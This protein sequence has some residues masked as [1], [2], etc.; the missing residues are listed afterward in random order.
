MVIR[1]RKCAQCKRRLEGEHRTQPSPPH[2]SPALLREREWLVGIRTRGG[3]LGM[4]A[5]GDERPSLSILFTTA[6]HLLC[7]SGHGGRGG[8]FA[9]GVGGWRGWREEPLQRRALAHDHQAC[10]V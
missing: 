5:L 2:A 9:W 1:Y 8:A 3:Y 7:R 6:A 10:K 4:P